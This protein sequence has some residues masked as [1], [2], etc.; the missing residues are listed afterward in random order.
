MDGACGI[1]S[2][3]IAL[4]VLLWLNTVFLWLAGA[5]DYIK[6]DDEDHYDTWSI[7]GPETAS[8]FSSSCSDSAAICVAMVGFWIA[9]VAASFAFFCS[10]PWYNCCCIPRPASR[11]RRLYSL[12]GDAGLPRR[13]A[14]LNRPRTV[15]ALFWGLAFLV[16]IAPDGDDPRANVVL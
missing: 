8:I 3:H 10:I 11:W 14:H 1:G 6:V 4:I 9:G 16:A 12:D 15:R 13:H 5:T 2:K 7:A